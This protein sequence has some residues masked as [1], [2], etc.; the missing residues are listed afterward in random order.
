MI[1]SPAADIARAAALALSAKPAYA[2]L[3]MEVETHLQTGGRGR[4]GGPPDQFGIDTALSMA[5]LL[6][7]MATLA[8]TVYSDLKNRNDQTKETGVIVN[9][10]KREFMDD[11]AWDEAAARAV[12]QAVADH[13]KK[14]GD[15]R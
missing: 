1:P 5:S 6:V 3:P 2:R 8:W 12:A 9:S 10:L 15:G 13:M 4:G 7:S 14:T 11:D